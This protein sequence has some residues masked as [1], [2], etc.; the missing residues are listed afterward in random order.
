M[1]ETLD[2]GLAR[3]FGGAP[4]VE[5]RAAAPAPPP[6]GA[7]GLPADDVRRLAQEAA[8]AYDRAMAAQRAGDWAAY[9]EAMRQV[10]DLLGRLR[11]LIQGGG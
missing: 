9:G 1:E 7:E 11:E 5:S 8:R 2:E 4:P 6:V 3:L 10:G